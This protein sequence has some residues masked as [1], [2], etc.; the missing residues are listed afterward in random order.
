MRQLTVAN[1]RDGSVASFEAS[2]SDFRYYPETPTFA[3]A[4]ISDETGQ[5]ATSLHGYDR[6]LDDR[7]GSPTNAPVAGAPGSIRRMTPLR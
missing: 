5:K 4:A 2:G 6:S 7:T 3:C 1:R